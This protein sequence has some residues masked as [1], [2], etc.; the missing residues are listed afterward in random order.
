MNLK[1]M[2]LSALFTALMVIGAFIRLPLPFFG[3]S[4]TLQVLFCICSGLLLGPKWGSVSMA[5]YLALGLVGIPVFT[6][7]GG[8]S[9]VFQYEFG[10]LL[11]FIAM[12]FTAGTLRRKFYPGKAFLSASVAVSCSILAMYLVALPYIFLLSALYVGE[13]LPLSRLLTAF[14]VGFLPLDI[15][16]GVLAVFISES[17]R[18][19][20][21]LPVYS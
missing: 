21:A 2:M 5:C 11:G 10:Y 3:T 12:A 13:A 15:L 19:R 18:A 9:Y 6:K 7:G 16:K 20:I 14:C 4:F 8:I 17:L 1:N